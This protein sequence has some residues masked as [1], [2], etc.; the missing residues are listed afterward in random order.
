MYA[1]SA[2]EH[3]GPQLP[4]AVVARR[5]DEFCEAGDMMDQRV[6]VFPLLVV[7]GNVLS[8]RKAKVREVWCRQLDEAGAHIAGLQEARDKKSFVKVQ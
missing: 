3:A 7:S 4:A 6:D 1:G 2:S 8:F 5:F